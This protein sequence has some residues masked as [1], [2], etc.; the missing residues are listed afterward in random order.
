VQ[1]QSNTSFTGIPKGK[2]GVKEQSGFL[3]AIGK[4]EVQQDKGPQKQEL[5]HADDMCS[6][7]EVSPLKSSEQVIGSEKNAGISVEMEILHLSNKRTTQSVD[8]PAPTG[9]WMRVFTLLLADSSFS[10][11]GSVP[12]SFC[13]IAQ[14]CESLMIFGQ[15][16]PQVCFKDLLSKLQ[17]KQ[18]A[19]C[20]FFVLFCE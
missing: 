17:E 15:H 14:W 9:M 4:S 3:S 20:K 16:S 5:K 19:T 6:S 11:E 8:I 18:Q 7:L 2:Q 13:K 12:C 1:L 10:F